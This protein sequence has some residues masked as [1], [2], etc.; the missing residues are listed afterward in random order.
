[1]TQR[2]KVILWDFWNTDFRE[3]IDMDYMKFGSR[4]DSHQMEGSEMKRI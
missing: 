3:I 2:S 4:D 1:M